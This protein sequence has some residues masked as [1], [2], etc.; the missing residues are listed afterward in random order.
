M[1]DFTE[2]K[3]LNLPVALGLGIV[4]YAC[5][6]FLYRLYLSPIA[7]FPGLLLARATFWYEFYHNW[8]KNGQYYRRIEEMHKKY[9]ILRFF[10]PTFFVLSFIAVSNTETGP[11]VRVTPSELHIMDPLYFNQVFV[12]HSVRKS[13]SYP[14]SILGL[15]FDG[16]E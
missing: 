3:R 11:I 8:V 13:N 10:Q 1:A 16:K 12:T 4:L 14:R 2:L 7:A 6:L 15:G 9:G 5:G